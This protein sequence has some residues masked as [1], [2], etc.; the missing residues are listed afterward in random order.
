MTLIIMMNADNSKKIV[1]IHRSGNRG[2]LVPLPLE[3]DVVLR[4]E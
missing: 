3:R 1:T 2:E 4:A